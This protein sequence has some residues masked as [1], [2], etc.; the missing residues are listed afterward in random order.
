MQLVHR[1]TQACVRACVCGADINGNDQS[2][3]VDEP[4]Q[5]S[6]LPRG[7]TDVVLTIIA[8]LKMIEY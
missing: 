3:R 1:P 4:S 2:S 6:F 5:Q 7:E 8:M